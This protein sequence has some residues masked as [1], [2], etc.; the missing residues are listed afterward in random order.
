MGLSDENL[1]NFRG[2]VGLYMMIGYGM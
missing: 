2:L 1:I